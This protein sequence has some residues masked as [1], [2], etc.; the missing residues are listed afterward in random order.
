MAFST[1]KEFFHV[2][3]KNE[4]IASRDCPDACVKLK[5]YPSTIDDRS[6]SANEKQKSRFVAELVACTAAA[7]GAGGAGRGADSAGQGPSGGRSL[8]ADDYGS[9]LVV[10]DSLIN[11]ADDTIGR[12]QSLMVKNNILKEKL[13]DSNDQLK[14]A[15]QESA[16]IKRIMAQR[17]DPDRSKALKKKVKE[18]SDAKKIDPKDEQELNE[19][20]R[21]IDDMNKA[22]DILEAENGTLKRLIEKQSKRSNLESIKIEP[23]KS[24]D[25]PYLQKKIESLGKELIL[26]RQAED[27]CMKA[28]GNQSGGKHAFSPEKDVG[29]IQKILAERDALRKKCKALT[30][31]NEKVTK[32]KNQAE[33]AEHVQGDLEDNLKHHDQYI[34][35]MQ[36]EMEDMQNFYEGEVDKVKGN[37]E[38]LL[39][40]CNEMKQQLAVV[41]SNAQ[42][43]E[44]QTME[45]DVL[46]NELRKRD[47]AI[48]AYGT[49]YE[50][51]M[52]K[53]KLFKEGGYRYLDKMPDDGNNIGVDE[54]GDDGD[55]PC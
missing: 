40:R 19:L 26:L 21:A 18:L 28:A 9:N 35:D 52:A 34:S 8:A 47:I 37:E 48:S 44:C 13:A 16:E 5:S 25:I 41:Q 3:F 17:Y 39:C 54:N 46:R 6:W 38:L 1:Q 53:A 23:E 12:M 49:Q 30:M 7:G 31:L 27:E 20:M 29:N 10:G 51:L 15:Q 43:A 33:T 36:Q 45:I 11:A 24:S 14:T 55:C 22:H 42:K 50:Q 2:P 32:L 4:T